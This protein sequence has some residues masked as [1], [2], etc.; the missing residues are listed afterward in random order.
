MEFSNNEKLQCIEREVALR[1]SAYPRFIS[2][3]KL[4]QEKADR[5]IAVMEAVAADYREAIRA[6]GFRE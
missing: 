3:G 6:G 1:R 4:K 2:S 5:E